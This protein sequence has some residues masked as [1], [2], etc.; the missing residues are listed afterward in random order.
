[1]NTENKFVNTEFA[2]SAF[3]GRARILLSVAC[4]A[5][6]GV[7]TMAGAQ[8]AP[9]AM[10]ANLAAS[11]M[12][13]R[14]IVAFDSP[15]QRAPGD[16]YRV[17]CSAVGGQAPSGQAEASKSP[18]VVEG[19]AVGKAYDCRASAMTARGAS[20]DSKPVRVRVMGAD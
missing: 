20:N 16:R 12:E 2:S 11:S 4:L 10:P 19:L 5:V 15:A 1:M 6:L 18:A 13:G 14:V 7:A 9:T 3:S 8:N 17:Y